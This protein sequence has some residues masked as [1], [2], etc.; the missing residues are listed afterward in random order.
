MSGRGRI[1]LIAAAAMIAAL[2]A[3]VFKL[4]FSDKFNA[5][6]RWL[7]HASQTLQ[8][9]MAT[10]WLTF[11]LGQVLVAISGVLPASFIAVM[12][13][14]SFG[15]VKGTAISAT[16]TMLGGWIA[17]RLSRGILHDFVQRR[18]GQRASMA[19]LNAGMAREGWRLVMLLRVSPIMPFAATSYALGLTKIHERDFLLGTLATLPA[20]VG[21]VALGALGKQALVM[22]QGGTSLLHW[23]TLGAGLALLFYALNRVRRAMAD[24]AA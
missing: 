11:G 17:F 2:G 22:A 21:Y 20:L 8:M 10:N 12:A 1:A 14:V 4:V 15:L 6:W 19:R 18:F 9:W 7:P 3:V 23:A 5:L 16:T 24:L 13:G